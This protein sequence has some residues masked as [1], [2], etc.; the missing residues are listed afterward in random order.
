M[1]SLSFQ[2]INNT[3][4][5][6]QTVELLDGGEVGK[7]VFN[8]NVSVAGITFTTMHVPETSELGASL[9]III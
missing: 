7:V 1:K 5:H 2:R 8:S 4:L 3:L 6:V 9:I